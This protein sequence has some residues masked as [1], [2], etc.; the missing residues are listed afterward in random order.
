MLTVPEK[1]S[2]LLLVDLAI[3]TAAGASALFLTAA[4]SPFR[5]EEL[6]PQ[7]TSILALGAILLL[8]GYLNETLD[9][10]S[11]RSR[12]TLLKRWVQSWAVGMG[13]FTAG[14]F[15]LGAPWGEDDSIGIKLTRFAPLIFAMFL[16]FAVPLGRACAMR[17][18]KLGQKSRVCV[19]AGAG[20][21]AREFIAINGGPDGDWEIACLVDDDARKTNTDFDGI[22]VT[23]KLDALPSLVAQHGAAD[24]ILA[25][26]GPLEQSS[27]DGVMKCYEQGI[28]VLPVGQAIERTTG[29]VPIHS[30]ERKWFPGTF[31]SITDRPL[32]QRVVKRGADIAASALL[33]LLFLPV[34]LIACLAAALWQ[35]FPVVYRQQRVGRSGQLF[36]LLKLRTMRKDAEKDGPRW[37]GNNDA[38]IT[39]FGHLLRRTRLDEVPQLWNV[40]KG[41]MSLVGPRPE[42]PEFVRQLEAEIPFYRGRLAVKPGLTGWAQIKFGYAK[43]VSDAKTKLEYDLYYI[44]NRSLWLDFLILLQTIRVVV[45]GRGR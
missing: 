1:K 29:R 15:L 45:T 4:F 25:T 40:L 26:E 17:I 13:L 36:T 37:A 5:G 35:G 12:G 24:V 20:E 27:L 8:C 39:K 22:R 30:L 34:L 9:I 11:L 31:W 19:I 28:E 16:L 41:D 38:R 33:I 32:F 44:K 10:E 42:R 7:A 43:D 3:T 2:L 18:F 6:I 21:A 14:Y 23:G